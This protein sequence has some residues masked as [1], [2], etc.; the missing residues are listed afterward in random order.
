MSYKKNTPILMMV[1]GTLM[2]GFGNHGY[3]QAQVFKGKC[4]TI[5]KFALYTRGIPFV[6]PDEQIS[7]IKGEL[8]EVHADALPFIDGL[9][10]HPNWYERKLTPVLTE[11]GEELEAWLYF[12]P[13][14][15]SI[16]NKRVKTGDYNDRNNEEK[17]EEVEL[18]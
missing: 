1:Y 17:V 2:Q 9:E 12:M 16:G 11:N 13:D 4:E 14:R 8:Y 7:T 15:S 10:S 6:Y 5:N 3:I 18:V